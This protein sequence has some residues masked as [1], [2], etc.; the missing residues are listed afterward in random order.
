MVVPCGG[1][2]M[3]SWFQLMPFPLLRISNQRKYNSLGAVAPEII[4]L[5]PE[6]TRPEN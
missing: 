6:K 1:T 2:V 5:I 4:N 3:K